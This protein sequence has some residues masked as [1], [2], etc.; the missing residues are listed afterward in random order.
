MSLGG[1]LQSVCNNLRKYR[2]VTAVFL[3][4]SS[5]V[6]IVALLLWGQL[7]QAEG[8]VLLRKPNVQRLQ[9]TLLVIVWTTDE[10]GVS[11]LQY[12]VGDL[13]QTAV[14]TTTYFT[15]PDAPP[16][17]AYY[18]H[19]ATLTDLIP[20]TLYQ[21]RI[22]TNGENLTP[23]GIASVRSGKPTTSTSF[24][25]AA[26]GDTR[27]ETWERNSVVERLKQIQ[28]DLVVHAGDFAY[29][30]ASYKLF[31]E[32]YFQIFDDLLS[33]IWVAPT[34]GNNDMVYNGG[35]SFVDVF[36]NPE[37]GSGDPLEAELYYS[38]DYGNAHFTVIATEIPFDPTSRQYD[39]I[40]NDLATT[41]QPWKFV[42]MHRTPYYTDINQEFKVSSRRIASDLIPLFEAQ[43]VDVVISADVNFYE[44]MKPMMETS[45]ASA[46]EGG[47]LYVATGGG[48]V[49][50]RQAGKPPWNPMTAHKEK[51]HHLVIFDVD[52]CMLTLTAVVGEYGDFATQD[53]FDT[54]TLNRCY[55]SPT[56]D[57]VA[58]ITD[59]P[60]PL[61]VDFSDLSTGDPQSWTWNFGDGAAA[62]G[63]QYPSHTYTEPGVYTVDLTVRNP[64]GNDNKTRSA[65]ITV[66]EPPDTAFYFAEASYDVVE[67]ESS[68]ATISVA[69][70][71]PP[72]EPMTVHYATADESAEAGT[73]YQAISGTLTFDVGESMQSFTVPITDDL[74]VEPLETVLLTLSDGAIGDPYTAT[75]SIFDD[76][77][78]AGFRFGETN[79]EV[80][81]SNGTVTVTVEL[82][83]PL[84]QTVTVDY[85]TVDDTA[86][87]GDYVSA[88]GTL[89][90][91]AGEVAQNFVV[92]LLD[93]EVIEEDETVMLELL[94]PVG[95][96][97]AEPKTA[98]IT[99]HND[100]HLP[101][102]VFEEV[103]TTL[104]ETASLAIVSVRLTKA[105][106]EAVSVDYATSDGNARAGSDYEARSGTLQ[107]APH[108]TT[109]IFYVPIYDDGLI[110]PLEAINLRLSSPVNG[111]LGDPRTAVLHI[112][113]D[114]NLPQ[115]HLTDSET[116]VV[117]GV[118]WKTFTVELAQADNKTALVDY[119]VVAANVAETAVAGEDYISVSGTLAFV[120]GK[121][122]QSFTVPIIDDDLDEALE[123]VI[124]RLTNPRGAVLAHPWA[125]TLSLIDDDAPPQIQFAAGS[126]EAVE[127]ATIPITVTL[128]V[129]SGRPITVDYVTSS[130]TAV[131][132]NDFIPAAGTLTFA[133]G[134]TSQTFSI[135]LIDDDTEEAPESLQVT[136]V[137]AENSMLNTPNPATIT[138]FDNDSA[139][140]VQ[141]SHATYTVTEG[142][143]PG[144]GATAVITVSL[145][146]SSDQ[147]VTVNFSTLAQ[148]ATSGKD[149]APTTI[150]LAF[151]P[152]ST[153]QQVLVPIVD[154][155]TDEFDERVTLLLRDWQNAQP[156]PQ[157]VAN[158][159]IRDDDAPPLISFTQAN[160][161]HPE[162]DSNGSVTLQVV[163]P[164]DKLIKLALTVAGV[165]AQPGVDFDAVTQTVTLLPG[166][167]TADFPLLV[168]DDEIDEPPETVEMRL[169]SA[170]NGQFGEQQ[171]AV[172]TIEDD[173][174]PPLAEFTETAVSV[175]E[176]SPAITLT[177]A[178]ATLS[179]Q[180]VEL[181]YATRGA[182]ATQGGDFAATSGLLQFPPGV[183]IQ[184]I[185]IPLYDDV[186]LELEEAFVVELSSP[187]H[188]VLGTA[189]EAVVTIV[190]D[191]GP[192]VGFVE[193]AVFA[194]ES[195]SEAQAIVEL[196]QPFPQPITV[197]YTTEA[198]TATSLLDYMPVDG[199]LT[200]MP[201][202]ISQTISLPLM[203]DALDEADETVFVRLFPSEFVPEAVTAT[204]TIFDDDAPSQLFFTSPT[205]EAAE[206]AGEAAVMLRLD[207]PA[208]RPIEVRLATIGGTAVPHVDYVPVFTTITFVPGDLVE[209]I[210]IPL[211]PDTVPEGNETV[212]IQLGGLVNG[213]WGAVR[214][215]VL[216]ITDSHNIYL[217]IMR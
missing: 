68:T 117:E 13:S 164:S 50:L 141:F 116:T 14:V 194:V 213:D 85:E 145:L 15:T 200:F 60:A 89:T 62:W 154:D 45:L 189:H 44:R 196:S 1:Y 162:T 115:F 175:S 98:V 216:T 28:P 58:N 95:A 155:A 209:T 106:D 21:Y 180:D 74:V 81:E 43:G 132:G 160:F 206:G 140:L 71:W 19:E 59:G 7:A 217:P 161:A 5:L 123:A 12:G 29:S 136:L 97:L 27:K 118:G 24:R 35:Q 135:P 205:Y 214:T 167:A 57:F 107:F 86:D 186:A 66:T 179:E 149:Y 82:T 102:I 77:M 78:G 176:A 147:T 2:F 171:T 87:G 53:V 156:G 110:E 158:L 121:R 91:A 6:F 183:L 142:L 100:D 146:G 203:Q 46:D 193:T 54:Y 190:D 122:Q 153:E 88:S 26:I 130:G 182:T 137:N 139:P 169:L 73:D 40:E 18:I 31:E 157:T 93:D 198:G 70:T 185:T 148:T 61:T 8:L 79:Y 3:G 120:A 170:D 103:A 52:D 131:S 56:A 108:E 49:G 104:D 23:N 192:T 25:F 55:H 20:D 65:Y 17:D 191:D 11:E 144:L 42:V 134:E 63:K 202:V 199:T 212:E 150:A 187:Q 64:F 126:Y 109:Q 124:V 188:A 94:N 168:H 211:L 37:N 34:V 166:E 119:E 69:A 101:E 48:G 173:D 36:V 174:S 10:E 111:T 114:D 76:D 125:T 72:T 41:T 75:L 129:P 30:E 181:H 184:T 32:R 172:F 163:P 152:G 210:T 90:F 177:V 215:A 133:A 4:S 113:D 96:R 80:S 92:S 67:G 207:R 9:P 204:V 159:I 33:S 83:E 39:W 138:I 22:F 165:T 105:Y 195:E 178:L 143:S 51:V 197:T 84:S 112:A 16:Y 208:G 47:I 201:G 128:A 127:G 38:F 151:P 99:I